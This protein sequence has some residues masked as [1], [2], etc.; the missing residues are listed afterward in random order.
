MLQIIGI[1]LMAASVVGAAV[2]VVLSRRDKKR[3]ERQLEAEYGPR[4]K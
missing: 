1:M 2:T 3:L 4:R